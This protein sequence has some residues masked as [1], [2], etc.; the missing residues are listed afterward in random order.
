MSIELR[1]KQAKSIS[2]GWNSEYRG[3]P[4]DPEFGLW[5]SDI[6]NI[7]NQKSEIFPSDRNQIMEMDVGSDQR[8]SRQ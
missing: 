2:N 1:V 3:F 5:K 4:I 6:S 8:S 7:R